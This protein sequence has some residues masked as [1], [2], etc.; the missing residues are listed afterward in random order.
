MSTQDISIKQLPL[1]NEVNTGDLL[2]IQTPNSTATLDF[3]NFVIGLENTT[4]AVAF[5]SYDTRIR[6]ISSIV[7][8][9]FFKPAAILDNTFTVAICAQPNDQTPLFNPVLAVEPNT[10]TAFVSGMPDFPGQNIAM[11]KEFEMYTHSVTANNGDEEL[12]FPNHKLTTFNPS[13][14]PIEILNGG[15]RRQYY[16][17]LSAGPV[18]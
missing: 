7:S 15:V 16:I 13:L 11:V 8:D 18:L 2:L 3:D 9:T 5:S 10:T 6:G 14:L 1:I 12:G 17:M 4:F